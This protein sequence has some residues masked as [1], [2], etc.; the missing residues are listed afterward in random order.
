MSLLSQMNDKVYLALSTGK[1]DVL[2]NFIIQKFAG[3]KTKKKSSVFLSFSGERS[4]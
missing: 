4:I 1:I 2:I 3:L